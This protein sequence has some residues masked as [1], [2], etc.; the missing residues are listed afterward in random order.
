[1]SRQREVLLGWRNW[2][3]QAALAFFPPQPIA[4]TEAAGLMPNATGGAGQA[5][6]TFVVRCPWNLRVKLGRNAKGQLIFQ[7]ANMRGGLSSE[8]F[9][10]LGDALPPKSWRVADNPILQLSMNLL[11]ISDEPCSIQLMPPFLSP[12][13]RQWPGTLICGRFP[14]TDWPRPLN[15][16][17]EWQD[18]KA[19]WV[20]KR[21]EPIAYAQ[22]IFED[23]DAVPRLVEAKMTRALKR[24]M[25]KIDKVTEFARNVGPMFEN[26][27]EARPP[28]LLAPKELADH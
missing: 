8:A 17:I 14:I 9:S 2:P 20:L 24:H 6:R 22:A 18:P 27:A 3:S 1:M 10:G 7:R 13:F 19:E 5:A 25:T 28:T 16:A 26:A 23:P 12:S 15:A 4:E 11:F 21:G